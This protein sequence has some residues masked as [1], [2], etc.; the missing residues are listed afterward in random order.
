MPGLEGDSV[1][2]CGCVVGARPDGPGGYCRKATCRRIRSR[3]PRAPRSRSTGGEDGYWAHVPTRYDETHA[4]PTTLLVWLHGC[5]GY[6]S[7][8]IWTAR[9]LTGQSWITVAPLGREGGCWD[10]NDDQG[11]VLAA[12]GDAETHFNI[13]PRRV[14]LGGYSSGGDLAYRT[15]FY[16]ANDFAGV[17]AENTAPFRDTGSSQADS[18]AAAAWKFNVIHLAHNQD[19]TYPIGVVRAEIAAM[20]GAGFPV[21]LIK[22]DGTHYDNAEPIVNGHAVPGTNAD[23]RNLLL[24]GSTGRM[25]GAG[26]A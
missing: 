15:A 18:L 19:T 11:K 2:G 20:T 25:A 21:E 22:R 8:D 10:V 9:A 24:A 12:I 6:S 14:I 7:G 17:L 16:N 4:T 5:G 23:L 1:S 26:S 3:S 13:D